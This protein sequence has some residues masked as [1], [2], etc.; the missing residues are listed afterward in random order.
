MNHPA[1]TKVLQRVR[2]VIEASNKKPI[3][4]DG[5][6][7]MWLNAV[8]AGD[9]HTKGDWF[10]KDRPIRGELVFIVEK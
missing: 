1:K 10:K 8:K 5:S 2:V 3:Q 4:D 6:G 7:K 9:R